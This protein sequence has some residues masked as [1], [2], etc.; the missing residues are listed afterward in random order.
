MEFVG[1]DFVT[2]R[3][4]RYFPDYWK[5]ACRDILVFNVASA[6]ALEVLVELRLHG[7]FSN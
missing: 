1:K 7:L 2:P 4:D 6:T 3:G 5:M